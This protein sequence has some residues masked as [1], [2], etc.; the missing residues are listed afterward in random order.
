MALVAVTVMAL[1]QGS[2]WAEGKSLD[3]V[4][5]NVPSGLLLLLLLLLLAGI[6]LF[7]VAEHHPEENEE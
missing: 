2:L 7:L 5:K 1:S 4:G 3:D 6:W